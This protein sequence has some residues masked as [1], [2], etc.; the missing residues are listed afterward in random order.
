MQFAHCDHGLVIVAAPFAQTVGDVM[1]RARNNVIG[2]NFGAFALVAQHRSTGELRAQHGVFAKRFGNSAPARIAAHI[3]HR[4][5][6]PIDPFLPRFACGDSARCFDQLG[7]PSR[8]LAE[9]NRH[10]GA[11][12]VDHIARQQQRQTQA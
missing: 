6:S 1:L 8:G 2:G 4:G 10:H 5:K 12:P 3:E 9:G 7:I 11:E